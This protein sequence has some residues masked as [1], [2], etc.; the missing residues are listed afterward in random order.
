MIKTLFYKKSIII[1]LSVILPLVHVCLNMLLY[2][3]LSDDNVLGTYEAFK[4]ISVIYTLFYAIVPPVFY[5]WS[6]YHCKKHQ[7]INPF[8]PSIIYFATSC[9]FT[10]ISQFIEPFFKP[11]KY[12]PILLIGSYF[13]LYFASHLLTFL[14]SIV[15]C[16]IVFKDKEKQSNLFKNQIV[17]IVLSIIIPFGITAGLM[18]FILFVFYDIE[19]IGFY[20]GLFFRFNCFTL[21][22]SLLLVIAP[23]VSI[24]AFKNLKSAPFIIATSTAS[25]FIIFSIV[26][27]SFFS[28]YTGTYLDL[29]RY[30]A[31]SIFLF[32]FSFAI[33]RIR[34]EQHPSIQNE[35]VELN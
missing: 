22:Y 19:V 4:S 9:V 18:R 10:L 29:I 21:Y 31:V 5:L 8:V 30:I 16:L 2:S 12:Y 11:F 14:L 13:G 7:I 17:L 15:T 25:S 34:N 33:Y 27:K 32:L 26:F 28:S 3:F 20:I 23:F 6:F 35:T 24:F 1:L